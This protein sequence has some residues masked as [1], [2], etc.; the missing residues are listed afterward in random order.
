MD[1]LSHFH[2]NENRWKESVPAQ[3]LFFQLDLMLFSLW[4]FSIL[5]PVYIFLPALLESNRE[6]QSDRT[7]PSTHVSVFWFPP[8]ILTCQH[9]HAPPRLRLKGSSALV[10]FDM[11]MQD[12][13]HGRHNESFSAWLLPFV[14]TLLVHPE[15]KDFYCLPLTHPLWIHHRLA[16]FIP[17]FKVVD[18]RMIAISYFTCGLCVNFNLGQTDRMIYLTT[19]TPEGCCRNYVLRNCALIAQ[20]NRQAFGREQMLCCLSES[21]NF[22]IKYKVFV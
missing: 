11:L 3:T 2:F 4:Y 13:M 8:L 1:E 21:V 17:H 15:D 7:T 19:P 16:G 10:W 6:R 9:T 12:V 20:C 5:E 18:S 14:L 22:C